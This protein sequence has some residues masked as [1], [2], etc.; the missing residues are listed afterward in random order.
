MFWCI[1]IFACVD[2]LILSCSLRLKLLCGIGTFGF[3]SGVA[4]SSCSMLLI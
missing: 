1:Y 2:I 4:F 3:E